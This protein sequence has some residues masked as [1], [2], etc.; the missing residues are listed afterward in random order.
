MSYGVIY[1]LRHIE[2]GRHYVGKTRRDPKRRWWQHISRA[3][4][5]DKSFLYSA[6]RKYGSRAFTLEL[7]AHGES[8]ED[9]NRLEQEWIIRLNT[10]APNGFNL[11]KG[12]DGGIRH[13]ST[14]DK[15]KAYWAD[16][17]WRASRLKQMSEKLWTP[18]VAERISQSNKGKI[19]PEE[20]RLRWSAIH[21][22]KKRKPHTPEVRER[23]S[24]AMR[25]VPRPYAR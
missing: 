7:C 19:I 11:S 25:G 14:N 24:A 16:P 18:E 4:G 15:F 10:I 17:L 2:T 22:G 3:R 21:K 23:I 1:C 9:L 20:L 13:P 12:G 6:I 5:G 8:L